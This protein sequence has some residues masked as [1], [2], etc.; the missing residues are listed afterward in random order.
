MTSGDVHRPVGEDA[1]AQTMTKKSTSRTKSSTRTTGAKKGATA[2]SAK[3]NAGA[4]S[5]SV[6]SSSQ[7]STEKPKTA[8]RSKAVAK[9]PTRKSA[10]KKTAAKKT[11]AKKSTAKKTA[12]SVK[13]VKTSKPVRKKSTTAK[14]RSTARKSRTVNTTGM[15]ET[16]DID[17]QVSGEPISE[18]AAAMFSEADLAAE[19]AAVEREAA[20]DEK[21]RDILDRLS[22]ST[23]RFDDL[24]NQELAAQI[25]FHMDTESVGILVG[26]IEAH[27]DVHAPDAARVICEVG[28][29]DED[30]LLP[31]A[32]RLVALCNWDNLNILPFAMYALS[33]VGHHVADGL[34][35]LRDLFWQAIS[36]SDDHQEMAQA[37]AVR[38]LSAICAAGPDYA[39]TLAGALVD[40]LGKCPPND[41]AV[42]AES[43]LP[44]LGVAHSH[45]AKPVLDRRMKELT[46]AEVARL[47][48]AVRAA[49]CSGFHAAA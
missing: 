40:L 42:F 18:I 7:K 33:P 30:L 31:H 5:S 34:W 14:K 9:S 46:P 15:D 1:V 26:V 10:A 48:R 39:R 29:R 36:E 3:A 24:P 27:D 44:A 22:V 19:D 28:T 45:R 21:K 17:T 8:A 38:L 13:T 49:Q 20:L 16:A 43:V 23:N 32:E 12:K 2:K 4:K 11:T 41:V 6:K 25:I 37:A 47:R 35:D